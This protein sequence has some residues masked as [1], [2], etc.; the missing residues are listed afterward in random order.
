MQRMKEEGKNQSAA[1]QICQIKPQQSSMLS[2]CFV[3]LLERSYD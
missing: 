2:N 3:Q 1:E